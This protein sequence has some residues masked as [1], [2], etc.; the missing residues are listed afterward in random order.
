MGVASA[1]PK[2]N[3]WLLGVAKTT[4]M[5]LKGGSATPKGQTDQ[6]HE[7]FF[8]LFDLW[9]GQ[10]TP[11]GHRGGFGHLQAKLVALEGWSNHPKGQN[12]YIYVFYYFS[13]YLFLKY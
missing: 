6:S 13:L 4:P 8:F 5:A 9:G 1:T 2:P 3:K 10:S 7:I 12:I 11:K